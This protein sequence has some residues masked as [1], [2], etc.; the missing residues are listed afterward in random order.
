MKKALLFFLIISSMNFAEPL[1]TPETT[2]EELAEQGI[3]ES[4]GKNFNIYHPKDIISYTRH[5]F[6]PSYLEGLQKKY[7]G[8][9]N[10]EKLTGLLK[11]QE[12]IEILNRLWTER[13]YTK[14]INWLQETVSENHPMMM[15][16]LAYA[17][18]LRSPTLETYQIKSLPLLHVAKMRLEMD[19]SCTSDESVFAGVSVVENYEMIILETLLRRNTNDELQ[20]YCSKNL[21]REFI[22]LYE[23]AKILLYPF[24][25]EEK[26]SLPSPS[27]IFY[28]GLDAFTDTPNEVPEKDWDQI[29]KKIACE[30]L[31]FIAEHEA[32]YENNY[33]EWLVFIQQFAPKK[34]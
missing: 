20:E 7:H 30:R 21:E 2:W 5:L 17:Y 19:A 11:K 29:R 14:R 9:D 33:P 28:H 27:W 1:I 24:T 12:H 23:L 4:D 15:M 26:Y 6:E 10:Y 18:F 13:N 3:L 34:E 32:A 8:L 22:S 31:K 16:E 25:Q